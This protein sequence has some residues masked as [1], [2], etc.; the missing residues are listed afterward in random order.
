MFGEKRE[1][2]ALAELDELKRRTMDERANYERMVAERLEELGKLA[3]QGEFT[4]LA[5]VAP[6]VETEAGQTYPIKICLLGR[7]APEEM[8]MANFMPLKHF[9]AQMR[10]QNLL[11]DGDEPDGEEKE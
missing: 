7:A 9:H 6:G 4:V 11:P 8:R 5:A 1:K 3:L 2:K 10:A